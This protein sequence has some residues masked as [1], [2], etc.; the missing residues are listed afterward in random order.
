[1][2]RRTVVTIV[3]LGAALALVGR[4]IGRP[5]DPRPAPSGTPSSDRASRP[6][7]TA[8]VVVYDDGNPAPNRPVVF[9]DESGAV[10]ASTKTARDGSA[11]GP[12]TARGMITAANSTST[13]H[14]VTITGVAPGE[15]IVVGEQ[16]DEGGAG[17]MVCTAALSIATLFPKAARHVVSVGVND[18][19]LAG[20][21]TPV[22][23]AVL[24][25]F[26][27]DGKFR[28]LARALDESGRP[29]AYAHVLVEGC[30]RADGGP[31]GTVTATM[32]AWSTD[33]RTF[34]V[35][36]SGGDHGTLEGS[37]VLVPPGADG[38]ALGQREA[39]LAGEAKLEFLAPRPLGTRAKT[40]L[41]VTYEDGRD[42]AAIEE[43]RADLA[44]QTTVV[45]G[46]RLLPR[47]RD[48]IVDGQGT[49]R[50]SVR[51]TSARSLASADAIVARLAWPLSRE[52]VWTILAPPDSVARRVVPA[53]P[54]E[55]AGWRPDKRPISV[56]VGAVETSF[57]SGYPDVKKQGLASLED[58]PAA[59]VVTIRSSATGELDL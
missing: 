25:R 7:G 21:K 23:L 32:P 34:T 2:N 9:S 11:S 54:D 27:V 10:L 57:W 26:I 59:D 1:M 46:D 35:V 55:L 44:E 56:A 51:W 42:H 36:A 58:P 29:L 19:P 22:A 24:E 18:A 4:F 47:I 31:A 17:A 16:A 40:K 20:A 12:M 52:H 53:L 50:P 38:F 37:I 41:E 14:L 13:G 45:L 33:F 8:T 28:A 30:A 43:R 5:S 39:P 3:A 6:S 15:R 49:P 48:A